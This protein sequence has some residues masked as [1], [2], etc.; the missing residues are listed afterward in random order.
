MLPVGSW[1]LQLRLSHSTRRR[2][3]SC[4]QLRLSCSTLVR[5]LQTAVFQVQ[6]RAGKS[7]LANVS[8]EGFRVLCACASE[9]V[10]C[11]LVIC[12][13]SR[14]FCS[15]WTV[16][17]A[18]ESAVGWTGKSLPVACSRA[19]STGVRTGGRPRQGLQQQACSCKHGCLDVSSSA[20]KGVQIC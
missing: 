3:L 14:T 11:M 6:Q 5:Q 2:R 18:L 9:M 1:W 13:V 4:L 16:C 15:L 8:S 7:S 20:T 17:T 12:L 19:L 10:R